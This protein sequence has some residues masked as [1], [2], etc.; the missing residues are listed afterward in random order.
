MPEPYLKKLNFGLLFFIAGILT[1]LSFPYNPL[2]IFRII[3]PHDIK[4]LWYTGW[5]FWAAGIILIG[6]AY[7][8]IYIKKIKVL[9]MR[10]IYGII[11]HPLYLGWILSV[12]FATFFLFP[13]WI[14][15]ITGI[16]GVITIY[17][18]SI[19]EEQINIKEFG[20]NYKSYMERVPSMNIILGFVRI[21][22]RK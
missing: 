20:N 5:V 2:V 18:I 16:P 9:N 13:H 17:L 11:R 14:F 1:I 12:F 22:K 10:G 19:K 15:I 8:Y 7:Y 4:I 21:F 6:L 3:K